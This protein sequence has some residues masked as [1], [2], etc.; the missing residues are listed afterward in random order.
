M[1]ITDVIENDLKSRIE[2]GIDY[3]QNVTLNGLS[4]IYKVSLTPVR[5]AVNSLIK[6]NYI[7]KQSNGRLDIN[8]KKVGCAKTST[9]KIKLKP[10]TDEL[11]L[12]HILKQ[13]L[14]GSE[15]FLREE[16]CAERYGVGRTVIRGIFNHF[17]THGVI[18]HVPRCGWKV[19]SYSHEDMCSFL[20]I[21]E[22]MEVKAL[23]LA[24]G[25]IDLGKIESFIS[26]NQLDGKE[27]LIDDDLHEYFI[28]CSGNRYIRG[29]FDKQ[30]LYWSAL[31]NYAAPETASVTTMANEHCD[32]LNA[33][34][35]N[36]WTQA[37]KAVSQ[38]VRSQEPII[39]TLIE[40][41]SHELDDN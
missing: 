39:S 10:K 25:N 23:N 6:Q 41:L 21:R 7:I 3:P 13:S 32:I 1:K 17:A 14:K 24:K 29:F 33:I 16:A 28:E 11:L 40:K 8:K 26:K 30:G 18:A 15:V 12:K 31:F 20:E 9:V 19:H 2:R 22:I 4:E 38:H 35:H 5:S 36:D 37:R 34:L 27:Q